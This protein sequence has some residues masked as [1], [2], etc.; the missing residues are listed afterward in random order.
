MTCTGPMKIQLKNASA[1]ESGDYFQVLFEEEEDG[2]GAYLLIQRQLEDPD[3]SLRYFE[4]HDEDDIAHFRVVRAT[5]GRHRLHL[6]LARREAA[7][8]EV[9]FKVT[10]K[11]YHEVERVMRIM[12]PCLDVVDAADAS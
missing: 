4:A 12:I 3:S 11:D 2:E 10:D 1:S 5:L 9:T 7:E 8:L 6:R